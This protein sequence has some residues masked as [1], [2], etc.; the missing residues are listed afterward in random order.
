MHP[1]FC[2][3]ASKVSR[4]SLE[5]KGKS[6]QRERQKERKK[7]EVSVSTLFQSRTAPTKRTAIPKA[8]RWRP[9]FSALPPG[10]ILTLS[11]STSE[12]LAFSWCAQ[13]KERSCNSRRVFSH[14]QLLK[15]TLSDSYDSYDSYDW[16]FCS[17]LSALWCW[18][19]SA[20]R[21]PKEEVFWLGL[22][23]RWRCR[24]SLQCKVSTSGTAPFRLGQM[25]YSKI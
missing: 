5:L 6:C 10:T 19:T 4:L 20:A 2:L 1:I 8:W 15:I 21:K 23:C 16:T 3:V 14:Y 18:A 11:A 25:S 7:R 17:R 12:S 24:Q 22:Q 9:W 13:K